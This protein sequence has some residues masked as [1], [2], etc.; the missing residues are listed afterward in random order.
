MALSDAEQARR[1]ERQAA[2]DEVAVSER[3]LYG[4]GL[5]DEAAVTAGAWYPEYAGL[6]RIHPKV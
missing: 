2:A 4:L 3:L 5:E 6:T 1:A